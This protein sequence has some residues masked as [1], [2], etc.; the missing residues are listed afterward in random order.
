M[1]IDSEVGYQ[2]GFL[3]NPLEFVVFDRHDL[4][5]TLSFGRYWNILIIKA[6]SYLLERDVFKHN[7]ASEWRWV[8]WLKGLFD[9]FNSWDTTLLALKALFIEKCLEMIF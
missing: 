1:Q 9:L 7:K 6:V 3:F 8:F 2:H 5:Y 4:C